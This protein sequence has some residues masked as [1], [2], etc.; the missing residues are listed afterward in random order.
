MKN[1][2]LIRQ[3]HL[4]LILIVFQ[5]FTSIGILS[6]QPDTDR[7]PEF[8]IQDPFNLDLIFNLKSF[9]NNRY[10]EEYLPAII[11]YNLDE[12]T[13]IDRKVKIAPRGN[14][15]RKKCFIPPIRINFSDTAYAISLFDHLG[16]V[17]L[18]T[19]CRKAKNY[20]QYLV[21][22]Y[23]IYKVYELISDYSL[24]TWFFKINFI[25]SGKMN[26]LFSS[27]AFLI[28]DIDE[29][30]ERNNAIEVENTN[31]KRS[32]L[33]KT[34]LDK[35]GI[36]QF[37][38]GNTDWNIANLHNLKLIKIMDPS[39]PKP[40]PV[41]YDFDYCGL[42]AANYAIPHES[43]PIK[44]VTD[45]YYMGNCM[46]KEDFLKIKSLFIDRK[47]EITSLFSNCDKL[48]KFSR[49]QADK[50]LEDFFQIISD[51]KLSDQ[52]LFKNCK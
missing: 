9:L 31:L 49:T 34:V 5:V 37:M 7:S 30:A 44:T 45:R 29:M 39:Y 47:N 27:Y 21:K 8:S 41:P 13:R 6:A 16:K 19:S 38:I 40:I 26:R 12:N 46:D 48:E 23:L 20:E 33:N 10:S 42:V 24:K 52:W 11:S 2:P 28:E 4:P 15:R 17:K 14:Y 51:D 43:L 50:F 18:V 3:L 35:L 32:D 25:D 36:F 1:E 22:E